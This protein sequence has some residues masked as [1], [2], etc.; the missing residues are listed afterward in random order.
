MIGFQELSFGHHILI[1]THTHTH[2]CDFFVI[3]LKCIHFFAYKSK[4]VL[5]QIIWKS[6]HMKIKYNWCTKEKYV[7]DA[8]LCS[9]IWNNYILMATAPHSLHLFQIWT[10][11]VFPGRNMSLAPWYGWKH[12]QYQSNNHFDDSRLLLVVFHVIGLVLRVS[13]LLIRT[14]SHFAL[15]CGLSQK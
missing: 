14:D 1:V 10:L 3:G 5:S 11:K 4:A 2:K 9:E 13:E 8:L 7:S 15:A 6:C 12:L